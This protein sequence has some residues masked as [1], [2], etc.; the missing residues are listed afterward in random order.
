V[1]TL[2]HT[3]SSEKSAARTEL[4]TRAERCWCESSL[5]HSHAPRTQI[6]GAHPPQNTKRDAAN[7][8]LYNSLWCLACYFLV[9]Y[10]WRPQPR[11]VAVIYKCNFH[12][13]VTWKL[14]RLQKLSSREDEKW[15][16]KKS[17]AN[18]FRVDAVLVALEMHKKRLR[19]LSASRVY[20]CQRQI[21][22]IKPLNSEAFSLRAEREKH[23]MSS[24]A[25]FNCKT[26]QR[27]LNLAVR[28][29]LRC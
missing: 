24:G 18:F 29:F 1:L 4:H 27:K 11:K 17:W 23:Q 13:K 9:F 22:L 14:G 2:A 26:S 16:K 15:G 10:S 12:I 21:S 8:S 28:Q 25:D 19:P 5:T 20:L 6:Q 7:G 3:I